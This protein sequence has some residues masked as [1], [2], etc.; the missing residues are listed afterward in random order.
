MN[1]HSGMARARQPKAKEQRPDKRE[2]ILAAAL[3]LFA[4][5]G[6]HG[7]A[8]PEVAARAGVGAGTLYRYFASKEALVNAL[9]QRWKGALMG[10][11][12]ASF[13][14]DASPR[15]QFHELWQRLGRFAVEHPEGFAFLELHH[16]GYLDEESRQREYVGLLGL[17]GF[18]ERAQAQQVMKAA[19]PEVLISLVYGGFVGLAKAETHGY[20]RLTPEVLAA[21]EQ[22][23]WEAVRA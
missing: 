15:Q 14:A 7:T 13:P 10:A 22:V 4:E 17:K 18:V 5:R 2:A 3:S 12:T 8:V 16:H 20:L 1:I 11:L 9:Y 6:F 21:A 23:M 19:P